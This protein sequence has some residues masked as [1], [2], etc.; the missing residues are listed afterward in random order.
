MD[1][2]RVR[3]DHNFQVNEATTNLISTS[4][5]TVGSN[6]FN[7]EYTFPS[8][9]I[10][11]TKIEISYDGTS[12]YPATFYDVAENWSNSE[13]KEAQINNV[14]T[15]TS[16]FI[17]FERNSYFVRPLKTTTGNITNGI[18]IWYEKR[19]SDIVAGGTPLGEVNYHEIYAYRL[20]MKYGIRYPEKN[21]SEWKNGFNE[22]R[23]T[24]LEYE[25]NRFKKNFVLRSKFENFK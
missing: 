18:H 14:F 11:P 24:M 25:K 12:W 16:P 15:Q 4:G 6:G 22:L 9:L 10:K 23:T 17:R 1:I 7:G 2:L 13:H 8:D 21:N 3:T 20:A 5:L 19:Q